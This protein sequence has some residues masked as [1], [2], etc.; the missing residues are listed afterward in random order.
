[1]I[2]KLWDEDN[3][4]VSKLSGRLPPH[5]GEP[6]RGHHKRYTECRD[7]EKHSSHACTN[8]IAK[9]KCILKSSEPKCIRCEI[10]NKSASLNSKK[11]CGPKPKRVS[12]NENYKFKSYKGCWRNI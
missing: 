9:R 6:H 11:K 5:P 7:Q 8:S 2:K 4:V 1:M 10:V 12:F 3:N